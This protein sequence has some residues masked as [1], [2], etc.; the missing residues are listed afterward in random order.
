[1]SS[2]GPEQ[3]PLLRPDEVSTAAP[4][5][6]RG[7][8][9]LGPYR[10]SGRETPPY[11]I[12]RAGTVLQVPRL[13]HAVAA[14]VDGRRRFDEIAAV[15]G[16]E[17]SRELSEDQVR[18]LIEEKLVP[19]GIVTA[20]D[21]IDFAVPSPAADDR[22]LALRFRW[23]VLGPGDVDAVARFLS[24]L[25]RPPVMV[26]ILA[27]VVGFDGW[28]LTVHGVSSPLEQTLRRPA[29]LLLVLVLTCLAGALHEFGHAAACHY[30]GARP[31][32]VGVG[33]YLIWPV[34]FTDVTDAYRLARTGRLRTDLG[35]I[36]CNAVFVCGLACA[37]AIT[38][39][40]VFLA[41]AVL[42]HVT[43][44]NQLLPWMRFDGYYVISDLT[45]VPDILQR[46]RPALRS[47]IPWQRPDPEIAG[48]RPRSRRTLLAYLGSLAVFVAVATVMSV[49]AAPRLLATDW[50]SFLAQAHALRMAIGM[51]DL[52]GGV[53]IT[54]QM[55]LLAA[56]AVGLVFGVRFLLALTGR[57]AATRTATL[58]SV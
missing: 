23:A 17:L 30:S 54:A 40:E 4:R 57:R 32:V 41:A 36:Y 12:G 28:L 38:G 45:G 2:P 34:F 35:G 16:A 39:Y 51:W 3:H 49:R 1:V 58:R 22:L 7:V 9:L 8:E 42:Q 6:A 18:F 14:A 11:L 5:L 47:L 19:A 15:A 13:L 56:P 26:A 44:L 20:G 55:A 37:Y 50:R 31:G 10:D 53:L 43:V 29:L 52:P 25:F 33:I 24:V 46:V 48:L 21:D 27:T